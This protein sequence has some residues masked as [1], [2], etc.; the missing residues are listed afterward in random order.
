MPAKKLIFIVFIL[1]VTA[2][3]FKLSSYK[4]IEEKRS[5]NHEND[6]DDIEMQR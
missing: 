6:I 3:S 5:L 2:S 1:I 4:R